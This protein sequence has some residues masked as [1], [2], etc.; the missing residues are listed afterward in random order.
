MFS[1]H[2]PASH[3]VKMISA[4]DHLLESLLGDGEAEMNKAQYGEVGDE[5][6]Q[7]GSHG[8]KP[9]CMGSRRGLPKAMWLGVTTRRLTHISPDQ[10]KA[11][12]TNICKNLGSFAWNLRS[13]SPVA[14]WLYT[15]LNLNRAFL[16]EYGSEPLGICLNQVQKTLFWEHQ[17]TIWG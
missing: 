6:S 3:S 13:M 4:Y 16:W 14:A 1:I 17:W 7:K 10:P 5:G 8:T 2:Q 11:F 15:S 9:I 12:Q